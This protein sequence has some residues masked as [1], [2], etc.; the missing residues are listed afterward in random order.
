MWALALLMELGPHKDRE[1]LW[2]GWS[3]ISVS[4]MYLDKEYQ[5]GYYMLG[6]LCDFSGY[7]SR[8]QH[9]AN[10]GTCLSHF[11]VI[12]NFLMKSDSTVIFKMYSSRTPKILPTEKI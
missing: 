9:E 12:L 8:S 6:D 10:R 3:S 11:F 1:K 5:I 4:E 7:Q 2:P